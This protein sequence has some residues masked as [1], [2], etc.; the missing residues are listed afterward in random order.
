[1]LTTPKSLDAQRDGEGAAAKGSS[2]EQRSDGLI[3]VR[4]EW[5]RLEPRPAPEGND[6]SESQ[7]PD[8]SLKRPPVPD[9]KKFWRMAGLLTTG[10]AE[11]MMA[12]PKESCVPCKE[13]AS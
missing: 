6:S 9:G 3:E 4:F 8:Q 2:S 1:M 5:T 7:A 12:V 11:Q 10:G 13:C